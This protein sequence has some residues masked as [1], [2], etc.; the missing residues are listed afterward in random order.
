MGHE[1]EASNF[2]LQVEIGIVSSVA[3][4]KQ[5]RTIRKTK[6]DMDKL[7]AECD[8]WENKAGESMAEVETGA[9]RES[10]LKADV[11]ALRQQVAKLKK[12]HTNE[13]KLLAELQHDT[14]DKMQKQVQT[15]EGSRNWWKDKQMSTDN[16]YKDTLV[17]EKLMKAKI[18]SLQQATKRANRAHKEDLKVQAK[19]NKAVAGILEEEY[20]QLREQM[21]EAAVVRERQMQYDLEVI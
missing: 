21:H 19:D 18:V 13:K 6:K 15:L 1:L 11:L 14:F 7:Q 2:A 4:D 9:L 17:L 10:Q 8:R 3:A 20:T 12:E 16:L 5:L